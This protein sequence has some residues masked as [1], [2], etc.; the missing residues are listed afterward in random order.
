MSMAREISMDEHRLLCILRRADSSLDDALAFVCQCESFDNKP[1]AE[2]FAGM[3]SKR[4]LIAAV[5]GYEPEE[6]PQQ[7]GHY[8]PSVWFSGRSSRL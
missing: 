1:W 8:A 5:L 6:R 7:T 2:D 3:T 4:Q